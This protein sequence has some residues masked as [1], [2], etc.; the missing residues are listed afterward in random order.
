MTVVYP[1]HKHVISKA[2][3][4]ESDRMSIL[5]ESPY[6]S[7]PLTCILRLWFIVN[8]QY[9][10][11]EETPVCQN[12]VEFELQCKYPEPGSAS[13]KGQNSRCACNC[14]LSATKPGIPRRPG[15]EDRGYRNDDINTSDLELLHHFSTSTYLTMSNIPSEQEIW[16]TKLVH[17]GFRHKFLLH[18]IFALS[19]LHL[20]HLAHLESTA[21]SIDYMVKAA[22]HQNTG[23]AEFRK[24][25]ETIDAS[26]FDAI[27]AFSCLVPMHSIV[28]AAGAAYRPVN[29]GQDILSSLFESISLFRSV[30]SLLL[31]W[32]D[33]YTS[34]IISP[35]LKVIAQK[36]PEPPST[37]LGMDSLGRLAIACTAFSTSTTIF[38]GRVQRDIFSPAIK[39]LRLTF[40]TTV[41]TTS[42]NHFT[43]R[44]ILSWAITVSDEY[45][46][47]LNK[48][49]PSALAVLAHW[50]VLLH[51]HDGVWWL[52]GLGFALVE[53]ISAELGEGW[54]EVVRW[55][56]E[57]VGLV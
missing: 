44:A 52:Q 34:S 40:A 31:P 1:G 53:K 6:K 11:G 41:D 14:R 36:L 9:K 43:I 56:R 8:T 3:Q 10:C 39:L 49:H 48:G 32:L 24:T 42:T 12:C 55:P 22:M 28:I 30:N 18:G 21:D 35:L 17:I 46:L 16:K 26:K 45:F 5:Q 23:L 47:Q 20:G 2:S 33:V 25:L 13:Q 4:K 27:L 57:E 15:L 51:R 38:E 54:A 19:A 7:K 37:L 29:P 50:A